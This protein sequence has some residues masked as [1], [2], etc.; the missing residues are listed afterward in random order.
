MQ[1][2]LTRLAT[3]RGKLIDLYTSDL[4][5][6][7]EYVDRLADVNEEEA[8]IKIQVERLQQIDS[9]VNAHSIQVSTA[10]DALRNMVSTATPQEVN[11]LYR[12]I[13]RVY[14]SSNKQ[15]TVKLT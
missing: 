8:R 12:M 1:G 15:L 11:I 13:F 7:V 9:D 5:T 2:E 14:C 3:K 6:R 10:V 4:I